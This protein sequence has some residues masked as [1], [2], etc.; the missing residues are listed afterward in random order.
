MA[1]G[2]GLKYLQHEG[3]ALNVRHGY[4]GITEKGLVE[5]MTEEIGMQITVKIERKKG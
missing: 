2:W 1:T 3:L 5:P 4:W